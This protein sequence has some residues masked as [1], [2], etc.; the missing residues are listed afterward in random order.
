[1][2]AIAGRTLKKL[3]AIGGCIA[4]MAAAWTARTIEEHYNGRGLRRADGAIDRSIDCDP[5]KDQE[6]TGTW[7]L[8]RGGSYI[9]AIES[10]GASVGALDLD[11]QTIL[12][13][14]GLVEE[15]R[16]LAA[17]PHLARVTHEGPGAMR[18][19]WLPPGRRGDL[20]YVPPDALRPVPPEQAGPMPTD[21]AFRADAA[22]MT[23][24]LL[25]L[26]ALAVHL[27]QPT[28]GRDWWIAAAI[29][30]LAL[31]IRLWHLGSFG[32]TWDEDVYWSS[33]RNYLENLVHLD[34]RPRMWRWNYQHPPIAKYI[35]G[36]GALWHDGY[37]PAR[38]LEALMGGATCVL[39]Y[40]IGRDLY[41]Q[42]VGVG[43][44]L[45]Y[46]FL[47]AA[48]AHSQISGL[49]TPS[50]FFVTLAFYLFLR[51]RYLGVGVAGGL[52]AA[53]RFVA[54]LVFVA[55]GLAALIDRP[56]HRGGWMRLCASPFVGLATL[57]VSWPRLWLVGPVAGLRESLEK[58]SIQ[59]APEWFLGRLV[60]A[61][62]PRSYFF[63]YFAAC[64]TPAIILGFGLALIYL[65]G[66]ATS[67]CSIFFVVPFALTLS[68]VIQNGVRYILPVFPPAA[69]L[70]AAGLDA[71][72]ARIRHGS[73]VLL[74]AA[75]LA[76]LF[77]CVRVAPYYL[78]YYNAFFGGPSA[79]F[80][81]HRFIVGWWGEGVS[82]AVDW[83]NAHAA[84]G[85]KTFYNLY[86]NHIVWLRDDVLPVASPA[87]ADYI[88]LNHFQYEHPPIGFREVFREQVV[89]GVPLSAVYVRMA[90]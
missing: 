60:V 55:I 83:F 5:C 87:D 4:A 59:H 49:E 30:G 62:V 20:E 3:L 36:L 12:R 27:V 29:L 80:R 35:L 15:Q 42:R 17:G 70:A 53:S 40:A 74:G 25:L 75:V 73:A 47:P 65:R 39:T 61:P 66:H 84:P 18:L 11:D 77:S 67:V 6:W 7:F 14:Q 58:L 16:I 86:P 23:V 79:A 45:L 72:G 31:A 26:A 69:I 56:K 44:G 82:A 89:P 51:Q 19:Y 8:P 32:Q 85:T 57:I 43:A 21:L 41:S 24:T 38:A 90:P 28:V 34:F 88:L 37:G 1:V 71:A 52:A 54:G 46:A 68:P 13:G 50:T 48:V 33:G 63:V 78:D 64:A 10:L 2:F 22:A 9:F 76:S 81:E